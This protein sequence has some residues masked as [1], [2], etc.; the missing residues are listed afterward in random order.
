MRR[1]PLLNLLE[2]LRFQD[3]CGIKGIMKREMGGS[4]LIEIRPLSLRMGDIVVH[5]K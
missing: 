2:T 1:G 4:E 3:V 5:Q